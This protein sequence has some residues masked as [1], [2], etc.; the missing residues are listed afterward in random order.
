MLILALIASFHSFSGLKAD[1]TTHRGKGRKPGDQYQ[2]GNLLVTTDLAIN[3]VHSRMGMSD[4]TLGKVKQS[5]EVG[6]LPVF[7]RFFW[8]EASTPH[9]PP[10]M[11]GT[12]CML[13]TPPA[14]AAST[15]PPTCSALFIAYCTALFCDRTDNMCAAWVRTPPLHAWAVMVMMDARR[16]NIQSSSASGTTISPRSCS[17]GRRPMSSSGR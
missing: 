2:D 7:C 6:F 10:Y 11:L 4:P 14:C 17:A 15:Y 16:S 5:I 9:T 8:P 12:P 1:T 13:G 3:G